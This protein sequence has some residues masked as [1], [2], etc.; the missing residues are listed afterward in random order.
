MRVEPHGSVV[1]IRPLTPG[2]RE[3][4]DQNVG[5]E[6]WQWMG[7][8]LACEPRYVADLVDGMIADGMEIVPGL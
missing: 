8:A 4:I 5:P 7:G 6:P 2:A 3:W 1:L